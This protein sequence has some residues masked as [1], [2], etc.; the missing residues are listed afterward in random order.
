[1]P[2]TA[3]LTR[4]FLSR[5]SRETTK[6]VTA[7]MDK[8]QGKR[9]YSHKYFAVESDEP[10]HPYLESNGH[11]AHFYNFHP[12]FHMTIPHGTEEQYGC[13]GARPRKRKVNVIRVIIKK[14]VDIKNLNRHS[15]EGGQHTT[16]NKGHV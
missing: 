3:G 7:H 4:K 12:L 13:V 15:G 11:I 2:S 6:E 8:I 5:Q 16:K 9:G 14:S 1:M 10:R